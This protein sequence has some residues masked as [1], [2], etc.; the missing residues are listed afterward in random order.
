M[1]MIRFWADQ[2]WGV[3]FHPLGSIGITL[4]FLHAVCLPVALA[5]EPTPE[6]LIRQVI[7]TYRS[8]A[9][10]RVTG[11]TDTEI[12][13][14]NQGGKV[15]HLTHRFS[16]LLKKPNGYHLTWED[17]FPPYYRAK[18]GAAWNS[19]SQLYIYHQALKGYMKLPTDFI[20]LRTHAGVSTGTTLI[21]PELFFA[22]F[23]EEDT[24]LSRLED[25]VVK[26]REEIDGVQCYVL[27]GRDRKMVVTYWIS[28]DNFLIRQYALLFDNPNGRELD[29][30]TTEEEAKADLRAQG[31]EPTEER[32]QNFIRTLEIS[33]KVLKK[34]RS[35]VIATHHF[36]HISLPDIQPE[37]LEFSIPEGIP[38]KEDLWGRSSVSLDQD[39][40]LLGVKEE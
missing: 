21:I 10:Y 15:S 35:Q 13:D 37:N 5:D 2:K 30:D 9:T 25:P 29:L 8:L 7:N 4:V 11:Q 39:E 14:F 16:I 32:I 1:T 12:T 23:P 33:S 6:F 26:G 19:G 17:D 31:L 38:L 40:E 27:E 18:Q 34:R 22:F 20:N 24:Q 36:S 28:I 3:R